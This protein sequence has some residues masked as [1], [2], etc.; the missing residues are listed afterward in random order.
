MIQENKNL[1]VLAQEYIDGVKQYNQEPTWD[2]MQTAVCY[3]YHLAEQKPELDEENK[4]HLHSLCEKRLDV[5]KAF[6]IY[7]DGKK[8]GSP[9]GYTT[10]K[11]AKK[12]LVGCDDWHRLLT[13]YKVLNGTKEDISEEMKATGVFVWNKY[14]NCWRLDRKVWSRKIWAP[15]VKEHYKIVEQG[16]NI[17]IKN[18]QEMEPFTPC[19][20]K[21]VSMSLGELCEFLQNNTNK[22]WGVVSENEFVASDEPFPTDKNVKR[23]NYEQVMRL[24]NSFQ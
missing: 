3:G 21:V 1:D 7:R 9:T 2:L 22:Y 20:N 17:E 13:P 16:Y 24:V 6:F 5:S 15:Y 11:G 23:Y 4:K 18:E 10:E 8:Y 14:I 12:S 19:S